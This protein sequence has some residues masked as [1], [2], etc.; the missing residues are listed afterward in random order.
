[1]ACENLAEPDQKVSDAVD[2]R[3]ELDLR[4]GKEHDGPPM[5]HVAH[6]YWVMKSK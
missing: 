2:V 3:Q 5:T 1:M 6:W 4:I